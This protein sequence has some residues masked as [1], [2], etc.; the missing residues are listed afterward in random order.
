MVTVFMIDRFY[1]V[2]AYSGRLVIIP[3]HCP[4]ASGLDSPPAKDTLAFKVASFPGLVL[5]SDSV[6]LLSVYSPVDV[7]TCPFLAAT[8]C[9]PL[10]HSAGADSHYANLASTL[11]TF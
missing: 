5:G 1:Y 4:L 7:N 11:L 9:F 6:C 8:A 2:W 10:T 3:S